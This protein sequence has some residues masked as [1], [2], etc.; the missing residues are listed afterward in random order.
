MD[1]GDGQPTVQGMQGLQSHFTV[2]G[3]QLG[4]NIEENSTNLLN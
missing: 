3:V 4:M 2:F 1:Y